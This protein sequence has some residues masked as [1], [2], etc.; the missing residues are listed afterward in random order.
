MVSDQLSS[1][2]SVGGGP[3]QRTSPGR[4]EPS[5]LVLAA[6]CSTRKYPPLRQQ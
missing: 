4:L 5:M 3:Q 2:G 6:T 1:T